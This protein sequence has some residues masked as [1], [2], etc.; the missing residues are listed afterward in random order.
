MSALK[1]HIL[2]G[3]NHNSIWK[4]YMSV[5]FFTLEV[6]KHK[7]T[8]SR[9]PFIRKDEIFWL[10]T[11]QKVF[12]SILTR[13]T[14]LFNS[15]GDF[16][17]QLLNLVICSLKIKFPDFHFL[18]KRF[19]WPKSVFLDK[20]YELIFLKRLESRRYMCYLNKWVKHSS[21]VGT[22]LKLIFFLWDPR[23]AVLGKGG[24]GG[25]GE[26]STQPSENTVEMKFVLLPWSWGCTV[27]RGLHLRLPFSLSGVFSFSYATSLISIGYPQTYISMEIL[28]NYLDDGEYIFK[29]FLFVN[30]CKP[31]NSN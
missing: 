10:F 20:K 13:N 11:D 17:C 25:G 19:P 16:Q 9:F 21:W 18:E 24:G 30:E 31:H 27:H 28:W 7:N 3:I 6:T 14:F 2:W 22:F 26:G 4:V 1:Q 8:A 23:L 15:L 12:S 5:L 29:T